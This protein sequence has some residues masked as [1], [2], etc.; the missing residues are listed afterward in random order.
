MANSTRSLQR[1]DRSRKRSSTY[2]KAGG[3]I[4]DGRLLS[5]YIVS[6]AIVIICIYELAVGD[7]IAG[8]EFTYVF[9]AAAAVV[10]SVVITVRNNKAKAAAKG[11]KRK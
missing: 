9:L 11:K 1:K 2:R 8:G 5:C 10:L 4:S 3:T 6:A 7:D